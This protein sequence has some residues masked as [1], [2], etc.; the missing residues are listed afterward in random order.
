MHIAWH[1]PEREQVPSLE[2]ETAED[3]RMA[4]QPLRLQR[5]GESRPG[6][7]TGNEVAFPDDE[8][9]PARCTGLDGT[10]RR[11]R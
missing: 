10:I 7:G 3:R 8:D 2:A 5:T 4:N 6:R 1:L 11:S 9:R